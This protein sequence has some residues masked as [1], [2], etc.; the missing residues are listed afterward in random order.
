MT[1]SSHQSS[2]KGTTHPD[3]ETGPPTSPVGKTTAENVSP[4]GATPPR[5]EDTIPAQT[6]AGPPIEK[7]TTTGT[8]T[9]GAA[10]SAEATEVERLRA[11]LAALRGRLDTRERRR[12]G[13]QRA[14][15]IIAA[16]LVAIA[17][18]GVVGSVIGIWSARTVHNT[19]RWVATVSPLPKDPAV[20]AA[21]A[22]YLTNQLQS[23]LNLQAR[24]AS[25]LPSQAAFLA[26]PVGD[27]VRNYVQQTIQKLLGTPQFQALWDDANRRAQPQLV[28]ILENRSDVVKATG[29]TVTLNLLPIVNNA[30]S[31]VDQSLPTVFGHKITLPTLTSGEVPPDLRQRIQTQL[32]VTLPA[33]FAQITFQG[34]GTLAEVQNTVKIAE[35]T[36]VLTVIGTLVFLVLAFVVSINRR[37]TALQFGLWL[38]LATV[39]MSYALRLVSTQLLNNVPAGTYRDGA[40]AAVRTIFTGLRD[41][42]DQLFWLGIVIAVVAYLAGPGRYAVAIRSYTVRGARWVATTAHD[43]ATGPELR[44]WARRH[45]DPLRIAGVVVAVLVALAFSSWTALLVIVI[46]LI[47]YEVLVTLL[48]RWGE[49]LAAPGGARS[50]SDTPRPADAAANLTPGG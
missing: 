50:A 20:N 47:G 36:V 34:K 13:W 30:L 48:A 40:Q 44:I 16:V 29:N 43:L 26:A 14:R 38:A 15:S 18:F 39:V 42:G 4:Q 27:A 10:P 23:Q 21:V 33:N 22:A 41:R 35:R 46:L 1:D 6:A 3:D 19:D 25:S 8:A 9:T 49:G 28:A 11:E 24:V 5:P 45:L 12:T 31:A 7:T 32:G 17:A 37:R 2:E